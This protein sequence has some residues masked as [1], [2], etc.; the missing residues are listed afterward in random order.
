M[1]DTNEQAALFAALSQFQAKVKNPEKTRKASIK[2]SKGSYSYM[3][4]DIA[5][6][7]RGA[8]PTLSEF[9]LGLVQTTAI[10]DGYIVLDTMVTHKDG[11]A[12]QGRFPVCPVSAP[13]KDRGTAMTYSRRY[14]ACAILGIAAEEDVDT[15]EGDRTHTTKLAAK[16]APVETIG[17][18][19][20]AKIDNGVKE[21]G[22]DREAI[23][24]HYKV[25]SFRDLTDAQAA[26]V[27]KR[28]EAARAKQTEAA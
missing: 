11:G 8:L 10:E 22:G 21:T 23:L 15:G 9:G 2:S 20:A 3:Y 6:V 13:D 19:R 5:D 4:A 17:T 12:I 26:Q 14:A 25:E 1:T 28:I 24:R 16:P 27:E 18:E 7:L